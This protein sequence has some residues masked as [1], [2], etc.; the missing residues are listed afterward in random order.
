MN[1]AFLLILHKFIEASPEAEILRPLVELVHEVTDLQGEHDATRLLE[2]VGRIADNYA[3]SNA[4][5]IAAALSEELRN[6][7]MQEKNGLVRGTRLTS[8]MSERGANRAAAIR[9]VYDHV[10]AACLV[11]LQERCF[12]QFIQSTHYAYVLSLK[13]KETTF[14]AIGHFKVLRM[15]GEGGFGQVL[16]VIKRDCGKRYAMKV[17]R[18]TKIAEVLG[19][20]WEDVCVV[21]RRLLSKLHHPLLLNLGYAFQNVAFLVLVMD[22]CPG[23]DL[24]DFGRRGSEKLS[25]KQVHFVGLEVTAVINY[26]HTKLVMFRDLKVLSQFD[27]QV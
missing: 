13:A 22:L 24:D 15:L 4:P 5:N 1:P 3:A 7:M 14:L 23:G 16:G 10:K 18:K 2:I 17:M 20:D 21:E 25:A 8:L 19:T 27:S 26:L 6:G 12:N 11:E 9:H